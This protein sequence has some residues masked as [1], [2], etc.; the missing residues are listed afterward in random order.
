MSDVVARTR[1][2]S[3][4]DPS[5]ALAVAQSLDRVRRAAEQLERHSEELV[6]LA[7]TPVEVLRRTVA[8][9]ER[10]LLHDHPALVA[11][12]LRELC[13]IGPGPARLVQDHGRFPEGFAELRGLLHVL[14]QDDHGG[15]RQAVG[16]Y[17]RVLLEAIRRHLVEEELLLAPSDP[18]TEEC[19]GSNAGPVTVPPL[20]N[21]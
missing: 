4:P 11:R 20:R 15:N 19:R 8:H 18:S 7:T 3:L 13:L 17:G 16:Q 14:E 6:A 2:A 12:R 10:E 9:L 5:D 21:R 1:A